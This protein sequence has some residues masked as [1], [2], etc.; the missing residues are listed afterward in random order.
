MRVPTERA[1]WLGAEALRRIRGA[2][3]TDQQ[4]FLLGEC[5]QASLPLDAEQQREFE[6]FIATEPYVGV[7]AMNTTWYEKGLQKGRDEGRQEGRE[8]GCRTVLRDLVDDK[9]GPLA[10]EVEER[11][12]KLPADRL[13]ALSKA[14]LRAQSLRDLGLAD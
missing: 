9:F 6:R 7:K 2:P 4:R 5:V 1:A 13:V 12:Q 14:V 8:E 3:L 11:L 10:A